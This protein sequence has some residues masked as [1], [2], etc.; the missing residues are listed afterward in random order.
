MGVSFEILGNLVVLT[1]KDRVTDDDFRRAVETIVQDSR[2]QPGSKM[3]TYDLDAAYEPDVAD[4][5][6]SARTINSFM[7][8]FSRRLAVV[9]GQEA[10]IG[11]GRMIEEHCKAFDIKFRAFRDPNE[12]K[13][14]L[15]R[16]RLES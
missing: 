4:P 16:E 12:A 11:L 2:F 9:V 15:F 14:W 3:L 7:T 1:A 13:E 8:H 6:E 5:K 10:S